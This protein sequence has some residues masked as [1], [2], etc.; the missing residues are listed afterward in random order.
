M[1]LLVLLSFLSFFEFGQQCWPNY[2]L[3]I[4]TVA[5]YVN[6]CVFSFVEMHKRLEQNMSE[7]IPLTDENKEKLAE[8][9]GAIAWKHGLQNIKK[10]YA[11]KFIFRLGDFPFR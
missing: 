8:G 6:F 10:S 9:M 7:L 5:P 1:Y 3:I 4:H 11:K 2:R